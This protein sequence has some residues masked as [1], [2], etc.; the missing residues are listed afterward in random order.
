MNG[1]Q[2]FDEIKMPK[3]MVFLGVRRIIYYF[4]PIFV[5]QIH[6]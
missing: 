2:F 5:E 4:C 3:D 1:L 6:A